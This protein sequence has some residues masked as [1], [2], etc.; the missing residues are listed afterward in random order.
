MSILYKGTLSNGKVFDEN[1]SSKQALPFIV[2]K[3]EVVEGLDRA[4]QGAHVGGTR[5]ITIPA[6]LAYGNKKLDGIPPNSTLIFEIKVLSVSGK[7][8]H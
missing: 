1:F 8:Q 2:G 3:K 5:K 6:P 7:Q 4:V